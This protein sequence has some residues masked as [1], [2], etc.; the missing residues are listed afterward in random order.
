M[1]S[2]NETWQ[3]SLINI[4][5]KIEDAISNLNK[6]GIK[7]V[8]VVNN[9]GRLVGTIS[10]GDVRRGLL[11]GLT[12]ADSIDEI[13]FHSPLV[14]PPNLGNEVAM[15]L[16]ISNKIFQIPIV[17]ENQN[18]LGLYLWDEINGIPERDNLMV[19]MAGGRGTRLMPYTTYKPKPMIEFDG[20]P[21]LL[22]IIEK[23]K[24]DG[25]TKFLITIHYL[26]DIIRN[27]FKN[28]NDFGVEINYLEETE[29]MGTAGSLSML[30]LNIEGD[31]VVTNGDVISEIKYGKLLD[32][33]TRHNGCA[34]MAVSVHE[35]QN[36]FGVVRTSG[37]EVSGIEEKPIVRTYV[38]AG[39]YVL[40][41]KALSFLRPNERC[42]MPEL[43]ER[44]L[45]D[46]CKVLAFPMH[47]PWIDIGSP[48]NLEKLSANFTERN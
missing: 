10:D 28:G 20:K 27:Y 22:H 44:M 9:S 40:S 15:Q 14:A 23:A 21:M 6:V 2:R 11:R 35:W 18:V 41:K 39:V 25:I 42:D 30:E 36:P 16:M 19:I 46:S 43:F 5:S 4:N 26:G 17:D 37:I 48:V 29:P 7:I 1:I 34:T 8:L 45:R 33:H 3:K 31:I 47:E 38:N 12:L 24:S 32:F 13:V